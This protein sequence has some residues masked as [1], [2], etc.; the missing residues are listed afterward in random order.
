MPAILLTS[1]L[2]TASQAQGAAARAGCPLKTVAGAAALVAEA[3]R[4]APTLVIVDLTTPGLDI[5][6][7]VPQL[8]ELARRPQIL[9]FGPHVHE[10]R[11]EAAAAAGCDRV[12]SRGQFHAQAE[13]ILA[14]CAGGAA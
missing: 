14:R 2:M 12:I 7:L 10:A 3:A 1:D 5:Q 6:A 9:A 4:Q 8:T 13:Q 11:L